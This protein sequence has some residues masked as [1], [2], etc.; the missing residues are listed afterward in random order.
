MKA[1]FIPSSILFL[2]AFLFPPGALAAPAPESFAPLVKKEKSSE[3]RVQLL[4]AAGL[5]LRE[6]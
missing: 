2:M 3:Y 5:S 1:A 6:K 4:V